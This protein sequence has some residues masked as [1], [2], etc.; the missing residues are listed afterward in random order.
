MRLRKLKTIRV[1]KFR[2]LVYHRSAR[3][4]EPHHFRTLVESLSHSIIY[5]L[6]QNLIIQRAVHLDYL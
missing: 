2:E 6:A 4:S 1:T 5:R 3:I